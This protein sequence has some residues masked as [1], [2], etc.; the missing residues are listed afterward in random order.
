MARK[1]LAHNIKIA[2]SIGPISSAN[3]AIVGGG[4]DTRDARSV[5]LILAATT[6]AD[7]VTATFKVQTSDKAASGFKDVDAQYL[8][9]DLASANNANNFTGTATALL[10]Y[11]GDDD[12]IRVLCTVGGASGVLVGAVSGVVILGGLSIRPS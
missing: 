2:H 10:G 12:Y 9:G 5:A 8:T 6:T 1:D 7:A 3:A 4:V 11:T